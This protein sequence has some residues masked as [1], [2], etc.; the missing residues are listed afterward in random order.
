MNRARQQLTL[1]RLAFAGLVALAAG[2]GAEQTAGGADTGTISIV[3]GAEPTLPVPTLSSSKANVDVGS[4]LFLPLARPNSELATTDEASFEPMLA[5]AWSR[6]DSVTLAFE[7]D[8]RARWHD[9]TPVTSR[10]VV[11]SLNRARDSA[12]SP[13]Y[14]LLLRNLASVTADGPGKVVIG[15]RRAYAEQLFDAVY[16]AFP[17]PAHL[18]DTI[19]AD[20]LASSAFVSMPVG[21][22][23]YRWGRL[24]PG[25]R[26]ELNAVEDFFLGRPKLS[27]VMFLFVRAAEAQI[28]LM[29]D[30][31]ADA[32]EAA[33]LPRQVEQLAGQP[34]VRVQRQ[35]SLTAGYLLFNQKANGD[36]RRPHPIL[37]D[38]LV[39]RAIALGIDRQQ[40][41][42]SVFGDNAVGIDGPMG[43][44]SWI[45][46]LTPPAAAFDPAEARRLL[47]QQ[48]WR[49]PDG[50]GVLQ[51][52]G[53]RLALRL[54]YPG[55]SIPRVSS[56]EIIQS[57]LRDIGVEIELLRL[58]GPIWAERRTK[59]E[60]DI[61]FSQANLDPTPSGLVQSWSCAGIGGS[62]V[63]SICDP[64]F[65]AALATA[66][67]SVGDAEERWR[68][69][70]V[71]LQAG[72]PAAFLYSPMQSLVVHARYRDVTIRP[73]LPW[74]DLWRWSVDPAARLARDEP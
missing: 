47:V 49:D 9:G 60:F 18:L 33:L 7:L 21:N 12:I 46:R 42:T 56:A 64:A 37:A 43:G 17:L 16:Q 29:L 65:D 22:G 38:P 50:D 6:I 39:R 71:A 61:D 70:V 26:L 1:H 15:F 27:R 52:N 28:N 41:L 34:A 73:D 30:G 66:L 35:P 59:G 31:T 55:S 19:P 53:T 63:G 36:R 24:E 62:N 5:R 72:T 2:C 10:D 14:A 20:R 13:T 69:A 57:M 67:R 23:P 58:D 3:I 8:P 32:F 74:S 4:L 48:G 51:K 54:S 68:E 25:Q 45:R 44:A 40:L 11:W